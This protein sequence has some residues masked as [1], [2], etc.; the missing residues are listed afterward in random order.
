MMARALGKAAYQQLGQ[1]IIIKNMP[2][3]GGMLDW[4]ELVES[5]YG[6]YTLG[7]WK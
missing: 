2:G 1:N 3:A 6:G 5:R 4:N 7:T